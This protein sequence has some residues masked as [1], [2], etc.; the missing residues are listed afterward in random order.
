[1]QLKIGQ[2]ARRTGLTVRALHHYD[3]IGLL[4]PAARAES[5]Y[6]LYGREDIARLYRIQALR[7][8]DMSL[9]DIAAL[10]DDEAHGIDDIVAR[11]LGALEQQIRQASAL[12]DHL[13]ALQAQ[14]RA[15][16]ESHED[17]AQTT[18]SNTNANFDY[19]AL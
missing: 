7:R 19:D 13:S 17:T 1:M 3:D 10:L 12:R 11:Q 8:L 15:Q 16:A 5:G 6:R 2:L 14:L 4:K 9:A 18:S